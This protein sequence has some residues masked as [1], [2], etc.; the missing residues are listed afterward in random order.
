VKFYAKIKNRKMKN[1]VRDNENELKKY[2]EH[3]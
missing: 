1:K 3:G 2:E